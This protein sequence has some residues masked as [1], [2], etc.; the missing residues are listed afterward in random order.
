MA[1]TFEALK[2][3]YTRLWETMEVKPEW[4]GRCATAAKQIMAGKSRYE[5]VSAQTGV[6][7]FVIGLIHSLECGLNWR[8]ALCN[9][10]PI[11]KR[12]VNVPRGMGPW[13]TWED[14]AVWA[15]RYDKLDKVTEWSPARAAYSLEG[16][17]GWG[18]AMRGIS[19]PYLWSGSNQYSRGKYV[20]DGLWDANAVSQQAGAMCILKAMMELDPSITFEDELKT[21]AVEF[22]KAEKVGTG[23]EDHQAVHALLK[24]ESTSYSLLANILKGLGLPATLVG[25]SATAGAEN[26]LQAYA[27]FLSFVKEYGFKIAI[28]LVAIIIVAEVIQY[29]RRVRAQT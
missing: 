4:R 15:L 19:S 24:D 21:A 5:T 14:A 13:A 7:W 25:A 11:S 23:T 27:P 1:Y 26:G 20:A 2:E 17:N 8:G 12:T 3:K 9:G 6:P 18:Y 22:P 29:V 16:Y 28:G 10:D